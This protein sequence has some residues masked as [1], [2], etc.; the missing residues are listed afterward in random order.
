MAW[1]KVTRDS[2]GFLQRGFL[3]GGGFLSTT[4]DWVNKT[5]AT[6]SWSKRNRVTDTWSN[7][8]KAS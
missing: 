7:V 5:K 8:T 1:T 2:K 6:D 3:A 4:E